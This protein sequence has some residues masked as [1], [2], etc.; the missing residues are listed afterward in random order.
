[1]MRSPFH[2][3]IGL[4]LA[5][6]IIVVVGGSLY[7]DVSVA[8]GNRAQIALATRQAHQHTNLI[9]WSEPP[10]TGTATATPFPTRPQ[11]A[12]T[13]MAPILIPTATPRPSPT[14]LPVYQ[15]ARPAVELTGF[16]HQWQ[17]WNNC[18][19]ATLSMNL[20][21]YGNTLTQADIG[22][23]LRQDPDDKNVS[24][25]EL[26]AYARGQ[27][28]QAQLR[29]NGDA[30]LMRIFLSNGI[31]VIIETWLE[32]QPNDG[33]GHYRMLTGYNDAE[34]RW[35]GYDAYVSAGLIGGGK[36]YQGIAMPYDETEQLWTVFDHTYVLV[37]PADKIAVVQAILGNTIDERVM[38]ITALQEAQAA[39]NQSPNDP[40][41]WFNLGSDLV[42]LGDYKNA[43]IAYDRAGEI[44]LPWRMLWYQFGP[45]QAY[46]ETGEYQQVINLVDATL[47][48]T[49]SVEE[50][51][52][53]K[54]RALAALGDQANAR[55][56]L[57]RALQLKR[58]Y[59]AAAEALTALGG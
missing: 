17:T 28:Y 46:Y 36:P 18:G 25:E 14:P 51:Y 34:Q 6:I 22:A 11:A 1:M 38:W 26:V 2:I 9:S 32:E 8:L 56:A 33:M 40:Y 35:T 23:V 12:F 41:L 45:L 52:Y 49:N 10:A 39:V 50:L 31:P 21:Y 59:N 30:D 24:P 13:K 37:Y 19:P 16:N 47:K 44:G 5:T 20:S 54:G 27:G 7:S 55:P 48:N 29:V 15:S 4:V 57:Q 3:A 53:W 43:A 58:D 42:T